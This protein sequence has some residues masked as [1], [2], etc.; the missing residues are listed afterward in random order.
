MWIQKMLRVE[1]VCKF[2]KI[3]TK[4]ICLEECNRNRF[5]GLPGELYTG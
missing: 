2:L 3:S 5:T 4:N 1:K